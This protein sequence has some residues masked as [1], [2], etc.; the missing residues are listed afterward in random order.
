MV[1]LLGL[2]FIM[3]CTNIKKRVDRKMS[4]DTL[5]KNCNFDDS[6]MDNLICLLNEEDI[7][8]FYE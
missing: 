3:D 5:I 6:D 7:E 4:L 2:N 1:I 8:E